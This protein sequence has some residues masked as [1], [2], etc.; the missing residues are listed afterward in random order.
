MGKKKELKQ[1]QIEVS[2][3]ILSQIEALVDANGST[4]DI[5]NLAAAFSD[6]RS[7]F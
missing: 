5:K 3:K 6:V 7:Y 1:A 2:E 4:E